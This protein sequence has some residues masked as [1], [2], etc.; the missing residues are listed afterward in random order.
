MSR[1][2]GLLSQG[3]ST[4]D[5]EIS[6]SN[7]E[8]GVA[9]QECDS[10]HQVFGPAHLALWDETSP[11]LCQLWVFVEDFLGARHCQLKNS[12]TGWRH[13]QC[14]KHVAR[15]DSIHTDASVCPLDCQACAK[16]AHCGLCGIVWCLWLRHVDNGA[17]H[18]SNHDHAARNLT[19]HQVLGYTDREEVCPVH[20][21]SPQL[22][23]PVVGVR[24]SVEVLSETRGCNEVVDL[25]VGL[26][27]FRDGCVDRVRIRYVSVVGRNFRDAR[28]SQLASI[29]IC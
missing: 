17:G 3:V 20:V 1:C 22:L 12:V 26:N 23:H 9:E 13:L 19:F 5:T 24:D 4:I 25:A 7:V 6:T 21:H 10:S 2:S 11:L 28:S 27:D 14:S 8:T 15:R 16:V 29:A 18:A